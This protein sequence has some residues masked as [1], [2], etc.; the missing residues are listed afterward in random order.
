MSLG[1]KTVAIVFLTV[2]GLMAVLYTTTR[3]LMRRSFLSL[4]ANETRGA[5]ERAKNALNDDI[6]NLASSTNDYAAWD[7]TYTFMLEHSPDYTR[8]EFQNDTL[9]GLSI[10]SVMLVDTSGHIVFFKT[11]DW[12]RRQDSE[13]PIATQVEFASDSWVRKAGRSFAPASGI[14]V[15]PQG[16]ILISACPILTSRRQGPARGVLIMTR[17][18]DQARI[19]RLMA[20]TRS[21]V[22]ITPYPAPSLTVRLPRE[23]QSN[24]G[25]VAV[26]PMSDQIVDGYALLDDVRGQAVLLLRLDARRTIFQQGM[27][28]LHYFLGAFCVVSLVFGLTTLLLLRHAVLNRLAHLN[29]EVSGIA[30]RKDLAERVEVAGA[31]ELANLGAAINTM[32]EAL[33]KSDMQFRNI[34]ENIHQVFWIRDAI[35]NQNVFVSCAYETV[36]GRKRETIHSEP[37]SWKQAV[38]PDDRGIVTQMLEHQVRGSMGSAEYRVLRPDGSVR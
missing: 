7:R 32:L 15:L 23:I 4:E 10:N 29:A 12:L 19:D 6:S 18:L 3:I 34:A 25:A 30:E 14:L 31:D 11:Y 21:S 20:V 27:A 9:Q 5:V 1:Q 37:S 24:H 8:K 13:A 16:P 2:V 28:S 35:T 17:N 38:H 22:T 36:W 33:Q 26:Q